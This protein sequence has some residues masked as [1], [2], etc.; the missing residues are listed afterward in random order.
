MYNRMTTDDVWSVVDIKQKQKKERRNMAVNVYV[1]SSTESLSR[2]SMLAWI[3]KT[4]QSKF[5]KI[6]ELCTGA[7][8]CQL[9]DMMFPNSISLKRVKF[10]TNREIEYVYNYKLLQSSFI[11]FSVDKIIPIDRIVKGRI[12][13]NFAFLQW[14]KKFFDAN[15]DG[16]DY[17]AK[18]ARDFA[19]LGFN[20]GIG[21]HPN[22][23]RTGK[24]SPVSAA[25]AAPKSQNSK[26]PPSPPKV[27]QISGEQR[28]HAAD[29]PEAK[30]ETAPETVEVKLTSS[31]DM[32][33]EHNS[34]ELTKKMIDM[35]QQ[36]IGAEKERDFYLNKL[37]EIEGFCRETDDKTAVQL[38]I[39]IFDVIYCD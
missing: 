14:F 12:L 1:N 8:Y 21:V 24:S 23:G 6:E 34:E 19:S 27:L 39:K 17:D 22:A 16:R 13:D 4:L 33:K 29:E 10:L 26:L 36:L 20:N 32:E 28:S 30:N 11:K 7:A 2:D 38:I 15:F 3:N 35:R 37:N 25:A 31:I 9:M 5:T 18:A